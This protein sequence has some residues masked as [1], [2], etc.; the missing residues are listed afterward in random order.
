MK[1]LQLFDTLTGDKTPFTPLQAGRVGVYCCGPTVYDLSHIGHVRAAIAPDLMVRVL[2][3]AGFEVKYVRNVTDVD[4][5]IIKRATERSEEPTDIARRYHAAYD[6]DL[7][8][9]NMLRPDVVPTVTAHMPQ[10]IEMIEN[11]VDKDAAYAVDGDVYF[12]VNAFPSYGKLSKRKLEAQ[13]SGARVEVDARKRSPHD[14]ALWKSAKPGEP[15]WDSPWGPGRPGWHIECSAMTHA[16]LGETFDLHFGGRDLIFPH[17]ENEIAQS[18]ACFGEDSFAQRWMHNG[19]VNFDG[20]KMA[21]SLGNFFTIR[22]VLRLYHP[23]ALRYFM[24]GVHY[25]SAINFEAEVR[26]PTCGVLMSKEEQKAGRCSAG[27]ESSPELLRQQVRFPGLEEADDRLAYVYET[28]RRLDV[29]LAT[30]KD[31]GDGETLPAVQDML[32]TFVEAMYDDLN[33]AEAIGV[34]SAPLNEVNRLLDSAKGVNKKT[35]I[36]TLKQ[37]SAS[38]KTVSEL[39]GVF[40][41]DPEAFLMERRDLKAARIGLDIAQVEALMAARS[42][43][44]ANKDFAQGDAVRSELQA[45]GVD[46]R[47]NPEGSVWTL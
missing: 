38:M 44:R 46:V 5:K 16:H 28:L 31:P 41:R 22:E 21:K 11:L 45:L 7:A 6:E 36:R 26:C 23:E 37:F 4:D 12:S 14:F 33:S 17:H 32:P 20:E 3:H 29:L 25:R 47:D 30:A 13:L 43:A 8:Q 24:L 39:L 19:F 2:R 18:Q 40:G 35:R 34:L 15:A 9:L 27:H 1:T 10:I 42:E